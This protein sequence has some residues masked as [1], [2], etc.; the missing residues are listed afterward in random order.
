MYSIMK[1]VNQILQIICNLHFSF[2]F[3]KLKQSNIPIEIS[4]QWTRTIDTISVSIKYHFNSSI[5]PES[6]RFNNN[7]VIIYTIITDGQQIKQS[8]PNAEW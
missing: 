3:V 2:F 6:I 8:S 5:I 1:F 7:V 4:S